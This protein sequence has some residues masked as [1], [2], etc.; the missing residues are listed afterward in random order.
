MQPPK[1]EQKGQ[2]CK[3]NGASPQREMFSKL[4]GL[5]P[6]EQSSLSLSLSLF[7]RACI[8]VPL[9]VPLFIFLLLACATFPRY[10][11]VCFTFPVPCWAIPLE[12][13][14]CLV[15][16]LALCD[17]IVHD[18]CIHTYIHTYIH[19]YI[20]IYMSACLCVGD[21]ALCMMDSCGYVSDPL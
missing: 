2:G 14:Q 4:G 11:N 1:C 12:H 17:S 10:D 15:Y 20:Y 8:R 3:Q 18:A 9:H 13:W 7:S 5:A 6:P 19:I 21:C 16:F